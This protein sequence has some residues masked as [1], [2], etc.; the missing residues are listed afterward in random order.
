MWERTGNPGWIDAERKR[1]EGGSNSVMIWV[2]VV[3]PLLILMNNKLYLV[4][5]DRRER[6][7]RGRRFNNNTDQAKEPARGDKRRRNE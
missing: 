6:A 1:Q 4:S 2:C 5:D 7:E 3:F